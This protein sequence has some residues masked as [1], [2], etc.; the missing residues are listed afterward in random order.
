MGTPAKG[1][2]L[3]SPSRVTIGSAS[4]VGF[5]WMTAAMGPIVKAEDPVLVDLEPAQG[6]TQDT[7]DPSFDAL[8][9][10]E[11]AASPSRIII[12][13]HRSVTAAAPVQVPQSAAPL[14]SA[15]QAA[16]KAQAAPQ[17][18]KPAPAPKQAAPAPPPPPPPP[19]KT[20]AAPPQTQAS[21]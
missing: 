17:A 9:D 2:V 5:V 14:N 19:P 20:G 6:F 13:V 11:P 4:I 8:A 3:L 16:P 21:G 18:Q 12:E 7:V 1:P 15:P 10:V